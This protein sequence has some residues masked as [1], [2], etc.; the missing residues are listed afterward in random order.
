MVRPKMIFRSPPRIINIMPGITGIISKAPVEERDIDRMIECMVHEPFYTS[1]KYINKKIGIYV[2]WVCHSGSFSDC[3][4]IWNGTKDICLI[5]S[6]EDFTGLNEIQHLRSRG[7]GF[8]SKDAS[9]LV[10]LYEE[11]GLGFIERLNG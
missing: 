2:G 4:P 10:R 11:M 9:Y 7:H 8:E 5:F 1:G 3:M 6:G